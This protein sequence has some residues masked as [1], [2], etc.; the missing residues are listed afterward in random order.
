MSQLFSNV[1][2]GLLLTLFSVPQLVFAT[3]VVSGNTITVGDDGWYQIQSAQD[4]STVC[5]G[6]ASCEVPNGTYNV[7]NLTTQT[8]FE[9]IDVSGESESEVGGTD[10]SVNGFVISWPD[11]GWYQVQSAADFSTVCEGGRSCTV[12]AGNYVVIN[13][14]TNSRFEPIVV[15]G[16]SPP[17]STGG[18]NIAQ[19]N[20][21]FDGTVLSWTGTDW[22]QIQSPSD[23]ETFCEGGTS[24]AVSPGVYNIINHTINQRLDNYT[25]AVGDEGTDT[26]NPSS[27]PNFT[28]SVYSDT[29]A[30]LFWNASSSPSGVIGYDLYRDGSLVAESLDAR[31]YFE[32]SLAAGTRY[33]YELFAIDADDNISAAS[34]VQLVT[35]GGSTP[36][37][38]SPAS[39]TNETVLAALP[40]IVDGDN[41]VSW[42]FSPTA[43]GLNLVIEPFVEMPLATNGS[44]ARWNAMATLGERIFVVDEQ[45]GRIYEITNRRA[46]L[47]FDIGST[48]RN[49]VGLP[50]NIENPFHGGVRGLAFHPD[51]SS[52]G[53]FYTS[54]L[55]QRPS[56]LSGH[57]YLSDAAALNADSVLVEWRANPETLL[58][59]AASYRELFRVGIPEYDHPIKQ[60]AFHPTRV[61]TDSNYG[62]LYV[63][64]GDGSRESTTTVGGQGNNALGKVLRIN[65][66]MNEAAPYSVPADNPFVGDSSMLD[67]VFSLGHRNPH[68]L[69]FMNDGTLLVGEDGRDNIDEV[70]VIE[71]G[72]DYGWSERE[73]AY[74][75]LEQGTL[76]DGVS[77]LPSNDA[78]FDYTYPVA[79]FGHSGGVGATFTGQALGG[80]FVMENGS[81]LDGSYFYI[82]FPKSGEVFHSTLQGI[83]TAV[84]RGAPSQLSVAKTWLASVSFDHDNNRAT[85]AQE[86]NLRDIIRSAAGYGDTD[87]VDVRY[88]KGPNGEMYLMNKRNNIVYL[89]SNS[90]PG[91]TSSTGVGQPLYD[92][93]THG[94]SLWSDMNDAAKAVTP[95]DCLLASP[96]SEGPYYCFSP[97]DRRLMRIEN[98]GSILWQFS[99]PGENV[100]NHIEAILFVNGDQIIT[101]ADATP[102]PD[103]SAFDM[104]VFNQSGAYQGSFHII[105][106]IENPAGVDFAGVNL[107]GLDLI[108]RRGPTRQLPGSTAES[109][110]WI[111][112]LYIYAEYYSEIAGGDNTTL[113]GWLKEGA[114]RARVDSRTGETMDT[115]LFPGSSANQVLS[116]CPVP[117]GDAIDAC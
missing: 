40:P 109:P 104:S 71:S 53:L 29:Q 65:P 81:E 42:A 114:F 83:R 2:A 112:D 84:T 33:R 48:L 28:A 47:W 16:D 107:N 98:E 80:G 6:V 76:A 55:Q 10:V 36:E 64:H 39:L 27:P 54:L 115:L 7:I 110:V 20:Y 22:F 25:I 91:Y 38:P 58:V 14:S 89:V 24:C 99:L 56:S 74:V 18:D 79:Q 46:S 117:A 30:E 108:V 26:E 100:T 49:S 101:F 12:P 50:L 85:P 92:R 111:N 106:D 63:A 41:Q 72:A 95:S 62:L 116:E 44:P 15:S 21:S 57:L 32:S 77:T 5:E 34:S 13:H 113:D 59:D 1:N 37:E 70:N 67:E 19:F 75:Q 61:S 31:S 8:R 96:S 88:G 60:I 11:N 78:D 51:F 43:S 82:D 97:A 94:F 87:R 52:N 73:G 4:Y 68:H 17:P 102:S 105:P 90:L 45:D 23:Y 66:L 9:N 35:T 103:D 69:A 3:P 93:G 86:T